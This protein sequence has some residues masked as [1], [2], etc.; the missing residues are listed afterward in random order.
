MKTRK[1]RIKQKG[2]LTETCSTS[3]KICRSLTIANV[4]E[5][6]IPTP[7][8]YSNTSLIPDLSGYIAGYKY[9]LAIGHLYNSNS[10]TPLNYEGLSFKRMQWDN[11]MY[12]KMWIKQLFKNY[13]SIGFSNGSFVSPELLNNQETPL[14][15]IFKNSEANV[16]AAPN[17]KPIRLENIHPMHLDTPDLQWTNLA[18][19]PGASIVQTT[20]TP[21]NYEGVFFENMQDYKETYFKTTSNWLNS[22]TPR[23]NERHKLIEK[24]LQY[25]G[26]YD[27]ERHF[28]L[29]EDTRI[30][31]DNEFYK[32]NTPD[33]SENI[34]S[35][36]ETILNNFDNECKTLQKTLQELT[37]NIPIDFNKLENDLSSYRKRIRTDIITKENL[38]KAAVAKAAVAKATE[39]NLLSYF[40]VYY[41]VEDGADEINGFKV[42]VTIDDSIRENSLFKQ[43]SDLKTF[44][45]KPD[46]ELNFLHYI[47]NAQDA[48]EKEKSFTFDEYDVGCGCNLS[49]E[50]QKSPNCT[51]GRN[52]IECKLS[53][54]DFFEYNANTIND[55]KRKW[56]DLI[57]N[58]PCITL[59]NDTVDKLK[60][61]LYE[62]PQHLLPSYILQ[63]KLG[64]F[65]N[66]EYTDNPNDQ[67]PGLCDDCWSSY[68]S[69]A[70]IFDYAVEYFPCQEPITC[71]DEDL[72]LKYMEIGARQETNNLSENQIFKAYAE[73][74]GYLN[75][76]QNFPMQK[77]RENRVS[78]GAERPEIEPTVNRKATT[79]HPSLEWLTFEEPTEWIH[80][81]IARTPSEPRYPHASSYH[82]TDIGIT[83]LYMEKVETYSKLKTT[84]KPDSNASLDTEKPK[85]LNKV[86][87]DEILGSIIKSKEAQYIYL[88]NKITLQQK[89][90]C[91]DFSGNLCENINKLEDIKQK[92]STKIKEDLSSYR[93]S[94][95]E[96]AR[97]QEGIKTT[98]NDLIDDIIKWRNA[99]IK[100]IKENL[101]SQT[102]TK[103]FFEYEYL[104]NL[105]NTQLKK[106]EPLLEAGVD[107]FERLINIDEIFF[108]SFGYNQLRNVMYLCGSK[109]A[110][111]IINNK[112]S[113][114]DRC[115]KLLQLLIESCKSRTKNTP[116]EIE[117]IVSIVSKFHI[118]IQKVSNKTTV[119]PLRK[120]SRTIL[121]HSMDKFDSKYCPSLFTNCDKFRYSSTDNIG[122]MDK[123]LA[124]DYD[125]YTA[126]KLP[127]KLIARKF[128]KFEDLLD[129]LD[130]K[131][132]LTSDEENVKN[133]VNLF[134]WLCYKK[135]NKP[136]LFYEGFNNIDEKE[137]NICEARNADFFKS[138]KDSIAA[139]KAAAWGLT[140][141]AEG[142]SKAIQY[143][144]GTSPLIILFS[145][146]FE[147]VGPLIL[148]LIQQK[149][150][151]EAS[152][153]STIGG[154]K[155]KE[156]YPVVRTI[157]EW[158]SLQE[159]GQLIFRLDEEKLRLVEADSAFFNKY[160]NATKK[161]LEE[162]D[163]VPVGFII[164]KEKDLILDLRLKFLDSRLLWLGGTPHFVHDTIH[165]TRSPLVQLQQAKE[166]NQTIRIEQLKS[167]IKSDT[168]WNKRVCLATKIRSTKDIWFGDLVEEA[169]QRL[170]CAAEKYY[171]LNL[172]ENPSAPPPE[173]I[174]PRL[175]EENAKFLQLEKNNEKLI[176]EQTLKKNDMQNRWYF[177]TNSWSKIKMLR[178]F[179]FKI[180]SKYI[181]DNLKENLGSSWYTELI[182]FFK[183]MGSADINMLLK[184][185]SEDKMIKYPNFYKIINTIIRKINEMFQANELQKL[186]Y[187]LTN[188]SHVPLDRC[189]LFERLTRA[190]IS[191]NEWALQ[192]IIDSYNVAANVKISDILT[193]LLTDLESNQ[194]PNFPLYI[195]EK[196]KSYPKVGNTDPE[197]GKF[198]NNI[199]SKFVLS[200]GNNTP[201]AISRDVKAK[202]EAEQTNIKQTNGSKNRKEAIEKYM[203]ETMEAPS[204]SL[205]YEYDSIH[206]NYTLSRTFI[207]MYNFNTFQKIL[208]SSSA[209][210]L[211][212]VGGASAMDVD[213]NAQVNNLAM[214]FRENGPVKNLAASFGATAPR[215]PME[216]IKKTENNTEIPNVETFIDYGKLNVAV[217][218]LTCNWLYGPEMKDI[219]STIIMNKMNIGTSSMLNNS[220]K[221][222]EIPHEI[223]NFLDYNEFVYNR[224][225]L[226]MTEAIRKKIEEIRRT[227]NFY[228]LEKGFLEMEWLPR[229]LTLA[230]RMKD[231]LELDVIRPIPFNTSLSQEPPSINSLI[232]IN[233]INTLINSIDEKNLNKPSRAF[234]KALQLSG[235]LLTKEEK[236]Y[237]MTQRLYFLHQN[238][239]YISKGFEDKLNELVKAFRNY[240]KEALFD[241]V[242][243]I[244]FDTE[245][246]TGPAFDDAIK[247]II[248]RCDVFRTNKNMRISYRI[249]FD[250]YIHTIS[251]YREIQIL[252]NQYRW[253]WEGDLFDFSIDTVLDYLRIK[254]KNHKEEDQI[255]MKRD[256]KAYVLMTHFDIFNKNKNRE[257]N[258]YGVRSRVPNQ[259]ILIRTGLAGPMYIDDK[260][261]LDKDSGLFIERD[262]YNYHP[263]ELSP[264]YLADVQNMVKD[265]SKKNMIDSEIDKYKWPANSVFTNNTKQ[266]IE[267]NKRYG[268]FLNN[269]E[270]FEIDSSEEPY[271]QELFKLLIQKGP[272]ELNYENFLLEAKDMNNSYNNLLNKKAIE[273]YKKNIDLFF[274]D[275]INEFIGGSRQVDEDAQTIYNYLSGKTSSDEF[276]PLKY[277][278]IIQNGFTEK[279]I[280]NKPFKKLSPYSYLAQLYYM[281]HKYDTDRVIDKVEGN[282][283]IYNSIN[284]NKTYEDLMKFEKIRIMNGNKYYSVDNRYSIDINSRKYFVIS[285][286]DANNNE[287]S[288]NNEQPAYL[289]NHLDFHYENIGFPGSAY[290]GTGGRK[291]TRKL[292]K[293]L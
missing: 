242:T 219:T 160:E 38:T 32:S 81:F 135:H 289:T 249:P 157:A 210:P 42:K 262:Y 159:D 10:E 97:N 236:I 102:N 285:N 169:S 251:P 123:I 15:N 66:G 24:Y 215:L 265:D 86:V 238:F 264:I 104:F 248:Q 54:K 72:H 204:L 13:E 142:A 217:N 189:L 122:I 65:K 232:L 182:D 125:L 56:F 274:I 109:I 28:R 12:N 166:K 250:D 253:E 18:F 63:N 3:E 136:N 191:N 275:K 114:K 233:E 44:L 187:I 52:K 145:V 170:S 225:L 277:K 246:P 164:A 106:I 8:L 256:Y 53:I 197:L 293:K 173:N 150:D 90:I 203:K 199:I 235:G 29:N 201:N 180:F 231:M 55:T 171:E 165:Q 271:E 119:K 134:N 40:F 163:A 266:N 26:I 243:K 74:L 77:A 5:T 188:T 184:N 241:E 118:S 206:K 96:I 83:S 151:I 110:D 16:E 82:Y 105:E 139:R 93:Y 156:N 68:Q 91:S 263:R 227:T 205:Q 108:T 71:L 290:K 140:V 17:R 33:T 288:L 2:G 179:V 127:N 129:L 141:L 220:E 84:I 143:L 43:E 69:L 257:F 1:N 175:F 137:M 107:P 158:K 92:I 112:E 273:I 88:L 19:E 78:N 20:L 167:F 9:L 223:V 239:I 144:S 240:L 272:D 30:C 186:T 21:E 279:P 138:E 185:L 64:Q 37:I 50:S 61:L 282:Y 100:E 252:F 117:F 47:K 224:K 214:D 67:G 49:E 230:Q 161:T 200:H 87:V 218:A 196:V 39:S 120:K 94:E 247:Y 291:K 149:I 11:M 237:K 98:L 177:Y 46:F 183:K 229:K 70:F 269:F 36:D 244:T 148:E 99:T 25:N 284:P 258:E 75:W 162:M 281:L 260:Y 130:P 73:L 128:P 286:K 113:E 6:N 292:V 4:K 270:R 121:K 22:Y 85:R 34:M 255:N 174:L 126:E 192:I 48:W 212:A 172:K 268:H 45:E 57:K 80:P 95:E 276:L 208:K 79:G 207:P 31:L 193:T 234:K 131:L 60:S 254:N 62:V 132:L 23:G 280:D 153:K 221:F 115:K 59:D 278:I 213:E 7:Y 27:V 14:V 261:I 181:D 222:I 190:K 216:P 51:P 76:A 116:R 101:P 147:H 202:R 283:E 226:G 194:P 103:S 168:E 154:S 155:T 259:V 178:E 195:Y 176:Y 133:G 89:Q 228:S 152:Q 245:I 35:F 211:E 198:I 58:R 267:F 209:A 287:R 41:K 124:N 111:V 146:I